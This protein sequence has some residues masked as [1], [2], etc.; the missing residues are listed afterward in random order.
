MHATHRKRTISLSIAPLAASVAM[1][2]APGHAASVSASTTPQRTS[3]L[4]ETFAL[5]GHG[6]KALIETMNE[7][8][9]TTA[10]VPPSH[11]ASIV[12]VTSCA[13]DGAGT[14]RHAA[15]IASSGDTLDLSTLA[16]STITLVSGAINV[17]VDDL[18]IVGP[19]EGRLAI[20]G[21]GADRVFSHNGAGTLSLYDVSVTHGRHAADHSY[22]GCVY[23]KGS[24]A[25]TRSAITSCT[26]SGQTLAAGGGIFALNAVSMDTSTVSDNTADAAG[27]Q[28][29]TLAAVAGGM[30]A[31]ASITLTHST[32]SGNTAHAAL[33]RS[34]GGGAFTA[35]LNAKYTTFTANRSLAIGD[36][37]D[38]SIGGGIAAI[39]SIF[40]LG[41]TIDHNRA[42]LAGAIFVGQSGY[43]FATILHSTVSSNT[44]NLGIG[45]LG[46]SPDLSMTGTTIA[47][48]T[49]G[50]FGGGGLVVIANATLQTSILADNSPTDVDGSTQID[51]A[52][53]IVKIA[54][55]N[56][57][58][59]ADTITLDPS[60]GDLVNNGG[61]TRTH[62]LLPGSAAIDAGNNDGSFDFDQRGPGFARVVGAAAD[63]G[64]VESDPDRIFTHGFE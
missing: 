29:G 45:G 24:V 46:V 40:A 7:R 8:A 57:V 36:T 17:N 12:P 37:T 28:S 14:L 52:D 35:S 38:Y 3:P 44:G 9:P 62:A 53:N 41:S 32:V 54:G 33:G 56:I 43:G 19:G 1:A 5:D 64:A 58:V 60:L 48:N 21:D 55:A 13:D 49:A 47:F 10:G 4:T 26:A 42:D 50:A 6:M 11:A 20:D 63:I 39:S 2:L 25:L 27:T 22:G 23:S 51:G 59:P 61:P 16:C 15:L 31:G 30:M 34:Y 18:S